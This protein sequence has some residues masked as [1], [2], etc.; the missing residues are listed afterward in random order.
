MWA[1]VHVIAILATEGL[2]QAQAPVALELACASNESE[3]TCAARAGLDLDAVVEEKESSALH[4]LQRTGFSLKA[5]VRQETLHEDQ[6]ELE[7]PPFERSFPTA[8]P[9]QAR[10]WGINMNSSEHGNGPLYKNFQNMVFQCGKF[11]TPENC[12]QAVAKEVMLVFSFLERHGGKEFTAYEMN[13]FRDRFLREMKR[14][15]R[16]MLMVNA[17]LDQFGEW[18]KI[19]YHLYLWMQP[20]VTE[21][22]VNEVNSQQIKW[23][24]HFKPELADI[25]LEGA[26]NMMG[27]EMNESDKAAMEEETL[28]AES[29]GLL[30][31]GLAADLPDSFDARTKWPECADILSHVRNQETCNNCW[32]HSTALVAESRICIAGHGR[33]QGNDAWLSQSYIAACRQYL[34]GRSYCDGGSGTLGFQI[35]NKLGVPT[36]GPSM[37]GNAGPGIRTCVPQIAPG[38]S[39]INCPSDCTDQEY[40]R[41][42]E[43]D[44]FFPKFSPRTIAPQSEMSQFLAKQSMLSEGPILIGLRVYAD[45]HAY[46]SGI[47]SPLDSPSNRFLGGHAITGIG[48]GPGYILCMNSWGPSFGDQGVFKVAP[49]AIDVAYFLPGTVTDSQYPLPV[50]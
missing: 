47:Y 20:V 26:A 14:D 35:V 25:S 22:L 19:V 21:S 4:L 1:I 31:L 34:D 40:P 23:T 13:S 11:G 39:G 36:G 37:D 6:L 12:T 50:P 9:M 10:K 45:L 43:S 46:K 16:R 15:S 29:Q 5:E 44:L 38:L 27:L 49:A 48:F 2:G 7:D 42:L 8:S 24:A 32:S 41:E 18:K 30:Q 3:A 17:L 28:R 33:M